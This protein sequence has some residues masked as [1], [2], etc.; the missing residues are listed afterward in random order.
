MH[1]PQRSKQ[2]PG[3]S[4]LTWP[5]PPAGAGQSFANSTILLA[6]CTNFLTSGEL[7][8]T[9]G[10]SPEEVLA[11][12][13]RRSGQAG[14]PARPSLLSAAMPDPAGAG[15]RGL[16]DRGGGDGAHLQVPDWRRLHR[17]RRGDLHPHHG[18]VSHWQSCAPPA[19]TAWLWELLRATP[20]LPARLCQAV[21][22]SPA[23]LSGWPPHSLASS[24][25]PELG[26][27]RSWRSPSRWTAWPPFC[28]A[29]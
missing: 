23:Q 20:R 3:L 5:A 24:C 9:A 7:L 6:A 27:C 18:R 1:A 11:P 29:L 8:E 14:T 13:S 26:C 12:L 19:A 10:I 15:H 2:R 16:C 4:P 25:R 17:S 22:C 28:Q 21:R